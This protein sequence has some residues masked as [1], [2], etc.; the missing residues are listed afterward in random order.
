MLKE[1]MRE[2]NQQAEALGKLMMGTAALQKSALAADSTSM[3]DRASLAVLSQKLV[4]ITFYLAKQYEE[5][6]EHPEDDSAES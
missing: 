6:L 4:G 2:L 3:V 5:D 1:E